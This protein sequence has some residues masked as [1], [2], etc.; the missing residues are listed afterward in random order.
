MATLEQQ[1]SSLTQRLQFASDD[2]SAAV[3]LAVEAAVLAAASDAQRTRPANLPDYVRVQGPEQV[4]RVRAETLR[5]WLALRDAAVA[6]SL[7]T[8]ELAVRLGV[9][10]AAVTKRRQARRL[11]AFQVKGDWRYP[12]WQL[13]DGQVLPG[14]EQ[15]WQ[16]LP[17]TVHDALGLARWFELESAHLGAPP[18]S[19][20]QAGQAGQVERVVDAAAYV[21]GS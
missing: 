2:E 1:V 20:L 7:S 13:R 6:G 12:A 21:G 16:A 3:E 17:L 8:S 4:A 18:L 15:A 9:S 19:L 10:S 14:V 5:D 11:V